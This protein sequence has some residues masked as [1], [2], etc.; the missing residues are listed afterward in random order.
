MDRFISR[1]AKKFRYGQKGFTLIE[2]LIVI[3]V[4]G[5]LAAVAIPNIMNFITSGHVAAANGEYASVQTA[6]QGYLAD[7]SSTSPTATIPLASVTPYMNGASPKGSYTLMGNGTVSPTASG[8][9]DV[10]WNPSLSQF[11][12]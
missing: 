10:T 12:K 3:A 7:H 1:I 5:I 9:A 8:W 11:S 6:L 4:L 2:L